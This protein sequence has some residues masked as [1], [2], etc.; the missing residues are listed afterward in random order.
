[1]SDRFLDALAFVLK[2]EGGRTDDPLDPGGRTNCG[3]TQ[4]AYDAFRLRNHRDKQDVFEALPSEVEEFYRSLWEATDCDELEWPMSL[5][6]FDSAVNIGAA[7][8][9][10]ALRSVNATGVLAGSPSAFISYLAIRQYHYRRQESMTARYLQGWL[11]R[12]K[13]LLLVA[14][15]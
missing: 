1:M 8:A 5:I 14:G 9:G 13:D 12:L 11:N 2:W 7:R 3:I 10:T 6:H 4:T 15:L